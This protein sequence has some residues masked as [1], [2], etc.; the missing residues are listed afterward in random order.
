M[1]GSAERVGRGDQR[2]GGSW[3]EFG[4]GT[5]GSRLGGSLAQPAFLKALCVVRHIPELAGTTGFA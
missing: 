4:W 1:R 5:E 3:G 2:A